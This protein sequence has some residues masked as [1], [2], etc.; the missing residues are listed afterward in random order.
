[1][2]KAKP[3]CVID[4]HIPE[5]VTDAR[6][7]VARDPQ[8]GRLVLLLSLRNGYGKLVGYKRQVIEEVRDD[9]R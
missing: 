5:Y 6:V 7:T 2:T 4:T 9:L 1:M 3:L 8:T